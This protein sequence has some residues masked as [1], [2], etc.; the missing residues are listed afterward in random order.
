MSKRNYRWYVQPKD[1]H[2]NQAISM[3]L[4]EKNFSQEEQG[5]PNLWECTEQQARAFWRS[6][7]DFGLVLDIY[8]QEG[9]GKIRDCGHLFK[10]SKK[11][12]KLKTAG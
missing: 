8:N 4:P 7:E 11:K 12:T 9:S 5:I 2:T 1:S 6:K 3:Q 10:K